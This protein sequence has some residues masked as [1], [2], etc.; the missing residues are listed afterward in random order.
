MVRVLVRVR[1]RNCHPLV[2]VLLALYCSVYKRTVHDNLSQSCVAPVLDFA[3]KCGV[4]RLV[5]RYRNVVDERV[6]SVAV[7]VAATLYAHVHL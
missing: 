1:L 5:R 4:V 2:V 6:T 3:A 7:E